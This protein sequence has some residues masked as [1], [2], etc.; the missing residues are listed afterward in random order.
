MASGACNRSRRRAVAAIASLP[1]LAAWLPLAA[2]AAGRARTDPRA[3][4]T[5]EV[6]D[7]RDGAPLAGVAVL[8]TWWT[9]LPP[10]PGQLLSGL[11]G[12]HGG[13]IRRV[14]CARGA[15]TGHDGAFAIPAWTASGQLHPGALTSDSPEIRFFKAGHAPASLRLEAW[16]S[17]LAEHEVGLRGPRRIALHPSGR[18]PAREI[19]VTDPGV[20]RTAGVQA[21][22]QELRVWASQLEREVAAADAESA[23]ADSAARR[24]VR[25]AQ[26][27][28]RDM[29]EAEIRRLHAQSRGGTAETEKP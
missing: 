17:G 4:I 24:E 25:R 29:I 28:M 8:A 5:G 2:C 12:G 20:K 23:S 18:R 11:A 6:V 13:A 19:L 3:A 26:R 7:A 15:T 21:A 14:A 27:P 10:S 16:L 9:E 22:L 1:G